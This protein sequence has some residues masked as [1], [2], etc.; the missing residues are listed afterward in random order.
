MFKI[1]PFFKP[2]GMKFEGEGD[3]EGGGG[4]GGNGTVLLDES[5]NFTQNF[6]NSFEKDDREAISQYKNPNELG[7]GHINLRRTFNKPADRVVVL[8][9]D[10]STDEER[11][12]F[13]KRL[14]VP[15]E[16][17]HYEFK[18]NPD[19]KNI[20]LDDNRLK[21]FKDIA[22][23]HNIPKSKF[24]GIVNDYL[25]MIDKDAADFELIQANNETKALEEDNKIADSYFGKAKEER[26]ALADAILRKYNVEIKNDKGEVTASA[27]DMLIERYPRLSHD[28]YL[29]MIIDKIRESMSPERIRGLNSLTTTPTN[30]TIRAKLED[31]KKNPAYFDISHKDYKRLQEEAMKLHEQLAS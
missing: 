8:P 15:D 4:G 29:V 23:K 26:V 25:A 16:A 19:I 9:D 24:E 20:E 22:K 11:A 10:N 5:G 6:Y 12:E 30:A 21:A 27:V 14:G 31:M 17:D 2:M 3:P 1:N 7:K 28:P 13:H 18:L